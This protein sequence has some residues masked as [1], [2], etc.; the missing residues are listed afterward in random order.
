[1]QE[2][3]IGI[4]ELDTLA[5][6]M[7]RIGAA[8]GMDAP[9]AMK[10]LVL[11]IQ[12]SYDSKLGFDEKIAQSKAELVDVRMQIE[13]FKIQHSANIQALEALRKLRANR[14][15]SDKI[16]AIKTIVEKEGDDLEVL[17][18]EV[19]HFGNIRAAIAELESERVELKKANVAL[20]TENERLQ[21]DNDAKQATIDGSLQKF[22]EQVANLQAAAQNTMTANHVIEGNMQQFLATMRQIVALAYES[23]EHAKNAWAVLIFEPL[24]RAMLGWPVKNSDLLD[25]LALAIRVVLP[26]L[27]TH[28]L[29]RVNLQN[30][31]SSLRTEISLDLEIE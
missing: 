20:R 30:A 3:N 28:N 15:E 25:R 18:A 13:Q 29:A 2:K 17:A 5:D 1:M 10:K 9:T 21:N 23:A 8:L 12:T 27:P 26:R 7:A 11:D 24:A 22:A 14:V 4:D 19:Q 31:L 6:V 16:L